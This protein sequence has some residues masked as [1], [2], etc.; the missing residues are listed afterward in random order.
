M[1]N[2]KIIIL[3]ILI[4]FKTFQLISFSEEV[5]YSPAL[6]HDPIVPSYYFNFY[7]VHNDLIKNMLEEL[8]F[9][10]ELEAASISK[11][12][13]EFLIM[14]SKQKKNRKFKKFK[15]NIEKKITL[16]ERE[17]TKDYYKR[18]EIERL[19]KEI[20][21]MN[22]EMK[23]DLYE[24]LQILQEIAT[25][26][27]AIK[28]E[29]LGESPDYRF[30]FWVGF[31]QLTNSDTILYLGITYCLLEKFAK[32]DRYLDIFIRTSINEDQY[33][34]NDFVFYLDAYYYKAFACYNIY[35]KLKNKESMF[36]DK[37]YPSEIYIKESKAALDKIKDILEIP[38]A[39]DKIDEVIIKRKKI[40]NRIWSLK[41]DYLKLKKDIEN[42][43]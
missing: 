12:R 33:V 43:K 34:V 42:L 8:I 23:T 36:E 37:I 5:I 30:H 40:L 19:K 28:S 10:K 25:D 7:I 29:M 3:F 4:V 15:K 39:E 24:N 2:K 11:E 31:E 9:F 13:K 20:V 1:R 18:C 14:E 17:K 26:N 6:I 35:I 41:E 21:L 32:S 38:N 22:L 16:L 27:I